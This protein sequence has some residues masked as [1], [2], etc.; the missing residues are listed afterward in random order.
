[1]PDNME[2]ITWLIGSVIT[3]GDIE[4]VNFPY[5]DL[6]V[7]MI[8]LRESGAKFY[9]GDNSLIVRGGRCYP[10]EISTGPH[11]GINS[12]IQPL[13]AAYGACARGES[14]IVDLRFYGRYGYAIEFAKMGVE[15]QIEGNMLKIQGNC[16]KLIGSTVKALDLRAGAALALLG[17]VAEGETVIEDAWMIDRGY[18]EFEKKLLNLGGIVS[19]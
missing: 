7:A 8:H 14:R 6:E 5:N 17:L 18:N 19:S 11:P 12:D 16:G 3:G 13:M 2:A 4:I 9:K 10:L 15:Y 1:M